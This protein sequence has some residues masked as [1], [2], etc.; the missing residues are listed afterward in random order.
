MQSMLQRLQS[1]GFM[2]Y[3]LIGEL[4]VSLGSLN[5]L[6]SVIKNSSIANLERKYISE[7][8]NQ[9]GWLYNI[10]VYKLPHYQVTA[11][12]SIALLHP[13]EICVFE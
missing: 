9:Q 3:A 8:E 6:S 1:L 12:L 7:K 4:V 10:G 5:E 11:S 2:D 13:R